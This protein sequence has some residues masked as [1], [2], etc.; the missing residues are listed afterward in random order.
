MRVGWVKLELKR[1]SIGNQ[2]SFA[3]NH[4]CSTMANQ[5]TGSAVPSQRGAMDHVGARMT[6]PP[7]G[8]HACEDADEG[9][10]NETV[11]DEFQGGRYGAQELWGDR[12]PTD[13]GDTQVPTH[14][15]AH[16]GGVLTPK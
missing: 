1:P 14:D 3:P 11:K 16:V 8:N 2:P 6:W 4:S 5:N 9:A 10:D 7:G 13:V 12:R 15:T